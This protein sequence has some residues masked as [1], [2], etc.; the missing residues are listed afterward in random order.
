[1][2]IERVPFG[3]TRTGEAVDRFTVRNG[4]GL[5][6]SLITYG[7]TLTSF[8]AP[9]REGNFEELLL[10]F[11]RLEAYEGKHPYFGATVGR[12]ANR[13]GGAVFRIG[14]RSYELDMNH[15]RHHIH[16]GA[17]GFSRR[18]WDAYPLKREDEAGVALALT[19]PDGDQGYPGKL[20]T[21]LTVMLSEKNELSFTYEAMTDKPT[22]VSLT[23]HSYWNL[24][25]ACSGPIYDHLLTLNSESIVEVDEELIPTGELPA[26]DGTPFDFREEKRIGEEIE[27]A[28]GYDHCYTLSDE[29]ALSIPAAVVRDPASGR[30]MELFTISPGIQFYSGNFL[31]GIETR[32][33]A[34]RQHT[35]FCLET[36]E[37]P[38]AMN[39]EHFPDPILH[40]GQRYFRKTVHHFSAD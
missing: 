9:D 13:I 39:H 40:P 15:G 6:F 2:E 31:S 3:K 7:A 8:I 30:R 14:E 16:G 21:K 25:G 23:N 5:S 37:Y 27:T 36:Q 11:D 18:I 4:N 20:D 29:H 17:G 24:A 12:Y 34:A 33:G 28:G 19:S 1:M 38:E 35:A 22:P 32:C 10:G 26:V